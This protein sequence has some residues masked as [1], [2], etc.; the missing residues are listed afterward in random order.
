MARASPLASTVTIELL[1][2]DQLT[3]RPVRTFPP[4]SVRV[5]VYCRVVPTGVVPLVGATATAFTA[6]VWGPSGLSGEGTFVRDCSLPQA[7]QAR[8]RIPAR[9]RDTRRA[10]LNPNGIGRIPLE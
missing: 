3:D 8:S 2:L 4:A 1:L 10:S 9:K 5:A 7:L 6:P